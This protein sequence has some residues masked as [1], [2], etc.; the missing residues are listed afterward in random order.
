MSI[1]EFLVIILRNIYV[2]ARYMHTSVMNRLR[3]QCTLTKRPMR[4]NLL[5]NL[6]SILI[7]RGYKRISYE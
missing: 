3:E 5:R 2:F 7:W 6:S 1:L 4:Q